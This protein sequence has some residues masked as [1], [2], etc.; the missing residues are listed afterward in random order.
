MMSAQRTNSVVVFRG[1]DVAERGSPPVLPFQCYYCHR[2]TGPI[3]F[4]VAA[5]CW[6]LWQ[7][8]D[9]RASATSAP[10]PPVSYFSLFYC[11]NRGRV[12][13]N[14]GQTKK[15]TERKRDIFFNNALSTLSFTGH[16]SAAER[17]GIRKRTL[18]CSELW[19]WGPHHSSSSP[20]SSSSSRSVLTHSP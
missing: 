13:R 9:E 11:F 16:Q 14:Y 20:S 1:V 15:I 7:P 6:L 5:Q 4:R 3:G 18:F 12:A 19:E 2:V 17:T 8:D 10:R